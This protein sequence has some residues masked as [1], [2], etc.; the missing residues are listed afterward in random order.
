[1]CSYLNALRR[2]IDHLVNDFA[3]HIRQSRRQAAVVEGEPFVIE[4]EEVQQWSL[5]IVDVDGVLGG[6][7]ADLVGRAVSG[8]RS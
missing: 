8:F 2:R 1:M 6:S 5:E 3:S 7:P 4:A